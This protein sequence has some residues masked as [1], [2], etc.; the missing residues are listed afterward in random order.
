MTPRNSTSPEPTH[1]AIAPAGA[2][3]VSAYER[4]ASLLV[5]LLLILGFLVFAL[6]LIW[7]AKRAVAANRPVEIQAVEEMS[8]RGDEGMGESREAEEPGVEELTEIEPP[9]L[10]DT[11][12]AVTT[13]VTLQP[14]TLDQLLGEAESVGHGGGDG[15]GDGDG[16]EGAANVVP[17]WHRWEIR[18]S[19]TQV[20]AYARQLDFFGIELAVMG[21][22]KPDVQYASKLSLATPAKRT[23]G[24]AKEERLRFAWKGGR[25][26]E[27]DRE[28]LAKAGVAADGRQV[29]QFAS[30]ALENELAR[31]ETQHSG[32]RDVAEIR[33]TVFGVES[34]D[35]GYKLFVARQDLRPRP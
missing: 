31:L 5:A 14:A 15:S 1:N 25:L 29:V 4:V 21:G 10:S 6:F 2:L 18:F 12:A 3:R 16:G 19:A 17:R 26:E 27:F 8:G 34:V 11:L 33:K 32:G 35:G 9:E 30:R 28:L 24:D 13:A 20:D 7:W 22:G 23:L